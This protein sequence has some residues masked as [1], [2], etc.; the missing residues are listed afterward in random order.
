MKHIFGFITL[1]IG[2]A[3]WGT[4]V[5]AQEP[6]ALAEAEFEAGHHAIA[7]A[8]FE[9]RAAAGDRGDDADLCAGRRGA[10]DR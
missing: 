6:A 9:H 7:L 5:H 10:S 2:L 8:L 4:A 1:S 3:T